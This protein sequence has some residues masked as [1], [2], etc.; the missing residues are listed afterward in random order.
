MREWFFGKKSLDKLPDM[1]I[2]RVV[3]LKRGKRVPV[4]C[5]HNIDRVFGQPVGN[6]NGKFPE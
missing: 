4:P 3:W 5:H 2:E 6:R 1:G